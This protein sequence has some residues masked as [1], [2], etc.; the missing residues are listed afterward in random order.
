MLNFPARNVPQTDQLRGAGDGRA[1]GPAQLWGE[2]QAPG[3]RALQTTVQEPW[4]NHADLGVKPDIKKRTSAHSSLA[5]RSEGS[6][7]TD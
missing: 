1:D 3:G 5:W 2:H 7:V 4:A 6:M